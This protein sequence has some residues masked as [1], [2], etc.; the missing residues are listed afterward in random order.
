MIHRRIKLGLQLALGAGFALELYEAQW[1][2][3]T[4][5]LFILFV[6]FLPNILARGLDL[7]V[8]PELEL[9]TIGFVFASVFLGETRDYYGRFW[10]WDILLHATSGG[11]LGAAGFLLVYV[12]NETPRIDLHMRSRF[13]ALFALCFAVTIGTVWEIFE[14]GVDR[15]FGTTMQKPTSGDATGLVD[16]MEDLIVDALGASVVVLLGYRSARRGA[17]SLVSRA[18]NRFVEANPRLFPGASQHRG[19]RMAAAIRSRFLDRS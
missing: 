1:M 3:A 17:D 19:S 5:V 7:F 2:N 6:T 8:P 14:F 9:L 4:L 15:V 18:I 12:L 10:W 13:L 16:T 11:L